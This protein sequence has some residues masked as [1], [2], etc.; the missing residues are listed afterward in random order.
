MHLNVRDQLVNDVVNKIKT[1]QKDN[2]H[3]SVLHLKE[4]KEFEDAFKKVR[5]ILHFHRPFLKFL[6]D[7]FQSFR[8]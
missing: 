4:K 7:V 3:K 6:L 8:L 5:M 1:W 2:Y